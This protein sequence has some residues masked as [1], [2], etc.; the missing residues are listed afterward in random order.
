MLI[1][2]IGQRRDDHVAVGRVLKAHGIKGE[3]KVQFFSDNPDDY[4]QYKHVAIAFP[5]N[6]ST[7]GFEYRKYKI[8]KFRKSDA[9]AILLLQG[10]VTRNE[11]EELHG[12]N[13]TVHKDE[14]EKLGHDQFYWHEL[15]GLNV[16][17]DDGDIVGTAFQLFNTKAHP[18]LVVRKN[19]REMMIP[20]NEQFIKK[21]DL[22]SK[23]IYITPVPGLLDM[24]E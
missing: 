21:I 7:D 18:L 4:K 1:R 16:Q 13:L 17:T 6:M 11:A 23:V 12:L 2:Y 15:E 24:N 9:A 19:G 3:I 5:D 22:E 8:E 20:A 10:I 14:L